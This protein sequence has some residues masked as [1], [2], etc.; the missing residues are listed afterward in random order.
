MSFYNKLTKKFA[1][2]YRLNHAI[3]I[4]SW[5]DAVMRPSHSGQA[6]AESISCLTGMAHELLIADQT[7]D[8]IDG[9][10]NEITELDNWQ[11]RNLDLIEKKY[12]DA[13]C[14]D[15]QFVEAFSHAAMTCEQAW[16]TLRME[17]DWQSFK[18]L[19]TD[20]VKLSRER[21]ERLGQLKQLSPYDALVD[22]FSPGINQEIIDPIFNHLKDVLPEMVD[23]AIAKQK[24][25]IPFTG[26]FDVTKQQSLAS[27]LMNLLGF[28]FE[29]GRLDVSHHPFCGGVP[30][31][32]P[33]LFER[34]FLAP[35]G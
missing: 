10:K 34:L 3:A 13:T 17:N 20:V 35:I 30:Q 2:I 29:R 22:E 4:L 9:A 14:F 11:Q 5:D 26:K 31:R 19:L 33:H 21:A 15:N 6:R 1:K 25:L 7:R 23:K 24:N 28:D 16:R 27:S 12:L 32:S 18:P 8:F